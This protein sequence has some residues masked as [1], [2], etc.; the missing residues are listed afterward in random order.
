MSLLATRGLAVAAAGRPLCS[1]LEVELAAGQRWAILGPNGAG[2]STLL[3]TLAG[4][5]PP[6]AGEVLLAGRAIDRLPRRVVAQQIGLLPQQAR[7]PFPAT[8]LQQVLAGRHPY[9]GRWQREGAVELEAARAALGAVELDGFEQRP[10][11]TLS[12]G[13]R[14]R[15]ELAT[16][17]CQ[18][19]P[20]LLLDEPTDQLDLRHQARLLRL[21]DEL[22]AQ[23]R[24]IVMVLHDP[25][26]AARHADQ[27]ILL[28]RHGVATGGAKELLT[29]ACLSALYDHPLLALE[30]PAG[31]IFVPL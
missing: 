16:L 31:R 27:V 14:R 30:H 2:K 24:T 18:D 25:T 3:H 22:A 10:I 19:P 9:L 11:T 20:I 28:G 1:G 29:A 23:G 12:G 5:Q 4:L 21:L 6:H 13:E 17:L 7:D 26:L 15:V 8:V